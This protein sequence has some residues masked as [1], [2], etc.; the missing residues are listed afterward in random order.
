[1]PALFPGI[2]ISNIFVSNKYV[3]GANCFPRE[4]EPQVIIEGNSMGFLHYF[5]RVIE[6][7]TPML[8]FFPVRLKS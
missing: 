4:P 3:T 8:Q 1:M 7:Q 5:K 2:V 6:F